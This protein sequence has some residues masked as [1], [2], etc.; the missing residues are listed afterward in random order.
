MIRK[1]KDIDLQLQKDDNSYKLFWILE[2]ETKFM[3]IVNNIDDFL[4]FILH[5]IQKNNN[6]SYVLCNEEN[7]KYCILNIAKETT[8][9]CE[10]IEL[11]NVNN[12]WIPKQIK[13]QLWVIPK[14]KYNDVF[15]KF[16]NN[17]KIKDYIFKISRDKNYYKIQYERYKLDNKIIHPSINYWITT[18]KN[19]YEI[20]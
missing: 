3:Q 20:G 15:I 1:I 12:Q 16:K 8:Y 9:A 18:L 7:C 2:N 11:H 5:K 17:L 4:I 10:I 14:Y 13:S 6:I 19:K